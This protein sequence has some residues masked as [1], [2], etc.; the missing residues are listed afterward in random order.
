MIENLITLLAWTALL[1]GAAAL[2]GAACEYPYGTHPIVVL[3]GWL[4]GRLDVSIDQMEWLSETAMLVGVTRQQ[5]A[6][7]VNGYCGG[8]AASPTLRSDFAWLRFHL[9]RKRNNLALGT[10]MPAYLWLGHVSNRR[11]VSEI[12]EGHL[13]R[14]SPRMWR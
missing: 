8:P 9:R 2:V 11:T 3:R 5:F 12:V 7:F 13:R 4:D 6:A 14:P 10:M 1:F